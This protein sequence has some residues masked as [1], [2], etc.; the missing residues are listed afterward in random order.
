VDFEFDWSVML[1]P[2]IV[3]AFI[4]GAI[5]LLGAAYIGHKQ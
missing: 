5:G 1:T 4:V 2:G 3:S